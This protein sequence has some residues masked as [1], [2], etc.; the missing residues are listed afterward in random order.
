MLSRSAL[1]C[2]MIVGLTCAPAPALSFV[3]SQAIH[4]HVKAL[5]PH[6]PF[7]RNAEGTKLRMSFMS[8]MIFS[9]LGLEIA[10]KEQ[11]LK[12]VE[13]KSTVIVDVRSMDEIRSTGKIESNHP[14]FNWSPSMEAEVEKVL[15]D[16]QG[17][18]LPSSSF[19]CKQWRICLLIKFHASQQQSLYTVLLECAL[20]TLNKFWKVKV[21]LTS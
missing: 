12:A 1:K 8:K 21:M 15:P 2:A 20:T 13:K 10:S 6:R 19:A 5:V 14:W 7:V 9:M 4:H 11:I 18:R 17:K 3:T 16:K